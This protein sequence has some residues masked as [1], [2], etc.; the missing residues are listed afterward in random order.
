MRVRGRPARQPPRPRWSETPAI[1]TPRSYVVAVWEVK[2]RRRVADRASPRRG[3]AGGPLG[4][5]LAAPR[6]VTPGSIR[7]VFGFISDSFCREAAVKRRD[8]ARDSARC[9]EASGPAFASGL[10]GTPDEVVDDA[11]TWPTA[12][13]ERPHHELPRA[14]ARPGADTAESSAVAFGMSTL[15][16]DADKAAGG[17]ASCQARADRISES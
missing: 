8:D 6:R 3:S 16:P 7:F 1:H 5:D 9:P 12:I 2:R 4:G 14:P 15:R 17:R 11:R 10:S 13:G